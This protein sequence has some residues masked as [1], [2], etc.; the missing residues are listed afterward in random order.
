[1]ANNMV[2]WNPFRD[3]VAMQN[4]MDRFFS[5]GWQ[6]LYDETSGGS[7]A[8]ALDVHEDEK[9]Y[10]V[11][12]ELPGVKADDIKIHVDGDFLVIEGETQDQTTQSENARP[13]VKERRYGH[14]S[15]R[16][17]LPQPMNFDKAD[18]RY[19]DGVLTLT[20]P[21]AEEAQPKTIQVKSGNGSNGHNQK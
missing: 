21:K 17:R 16:I 5:E 1:M 3:M 18:A 20:L 19:E 9:N 4:A 6:P 13:L 7:R 8:L 12:T 15:R 14:Y 11:T 10:V 2:R